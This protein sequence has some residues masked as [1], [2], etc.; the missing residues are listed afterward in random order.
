MNDFLSYVIYLCGVF[1]IYL[2]LCEL[3]F[4]SILTNKNS[5]SITNE[6]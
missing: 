1:F 3:L 2:L 6:Q 4:F 5:Y